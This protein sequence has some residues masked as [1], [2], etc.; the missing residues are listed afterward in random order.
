MKQGKPIFFALSGNNKILCIEGHRT[1]P[2]YHLIMLYYQI[3]K[4][5]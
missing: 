2:F 1:Y 3:W 4:V 5:P